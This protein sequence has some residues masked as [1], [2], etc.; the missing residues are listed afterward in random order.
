MVHL[1]QNDLIIL[2]ALS[3][4]RSRVAG[5]KA[6]RWTRALM[7]L[8]VLLFL[9]LLLLEAL[10]LILV[11]PLPT[12]ALVLPLLDRFDHPKKPP[13]PLRTLFELEAP[14]P[15]PPLLLLFVLPPAL[16]PAL[17]LLFSQVGR[18]ADTRCIVRSGEAGTPLSLP[19]WSARRAR[20]RESY[21]RQ[22][23]TQVE[24]A[25]RRGCCT[26]LGFSTCGLRKT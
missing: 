5:Q 12:L 23:E 21:S 24:S 7:T 2:A 20:Q 8:A 6:S 22:W 3:H 13:P 10:T 15:V 26:I 9:L 1:P 14:L 18:K 16:D 11:R 4:S 25:G 17:E 19:L